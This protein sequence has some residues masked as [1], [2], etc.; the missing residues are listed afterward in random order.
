MK[1]TKNKNTNI[2]LTRKDVLH[3]ASLIN[4]PLTE[5]EIPQ[6][7]D[8]LSQTISSI[9]K[10][11]EIKTTNLAPTNQVTGLENVLREDSVVADSR[12][13]QEEA[14]VNAPHIHA[15][16]FKVPGLFQGE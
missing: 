16:L 14:L 1:K 6:L 11:K 2:Q 8:Q 4:I 10:L 15:T 5:K 7:Q 9:D 3:I 13:T 12:L